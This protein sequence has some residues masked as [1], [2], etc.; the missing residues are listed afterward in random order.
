[1]GLSSGILLFNRKRKLKKTK[2]ISLWDK[3]LRYTNTILNYRLVK[4]TSTV[5]LGP[6]NCS[7][8]Y[9][10]WNSKQI[11]FIRIVIQEKKMTGMENDWDISCWRTECMMEYR[12]PSVLVV[13]GQMASRTF[14]FVLRIIERYHLFLYMT[15][16][17]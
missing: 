17:V 14:H 5:F 15:K 7:G 4:K 16:H 11:S 8:K 9:L 6:E 1:M 3:M 12:G 2:S 10:T 13:T